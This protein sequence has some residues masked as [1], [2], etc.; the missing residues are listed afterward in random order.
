MIVKVKKITFVGLQ[1]EKERFIARLQEIGVTH[2]SLPMDAVEPAEVSRELQKVTEI[3]KFLSRL[4]KKTASAAG[5]EDYTAIC[6]RRE[7]LGQRET[8]LL[9]EISVLKKEREILEPWG[10]FAPQDIAA[11]RSKGLEIRFYR[12]PRKVFDTLSLD[13]VFCL[14][15][16]QSEGEV[17]FTAMASSPFDLGVPEEKIP[18]KS[19]KQ[20]DTDIQSKQEELGRITGEY[21][22]LSEKVQALIEAEAR[23]KDDYEYRRV[24]L[25]AGPV[26]D[27][28][29][30][31]LTCWSPVPEEDLLKR[32]GE[33]FTLGH[34]SED[35]AEGEKVPVLL[36]NR[37]AFESCEDLVKVYSQPN[38]GDFDPSGLVLYIF[39]IF[40]GMIIGD[41]GYGLVSLALTILLHWKV[42]SDSPLWFRFRRLCYLL[43]F[44][45]L[46][47]GIISASYFGIALRPENPLNKLLLLDLNT[48]EGQNQVMLISVIMGMIHISIALAIKFYRTKD[49]PTLGWIIVIW[50]GYFLLSSKMGKGEENPVAMYIAIVGMALVV[51]FT[52]NSKNPILRILIGL[53]GAL[54]VVQLLA[55][56]LSYMRLFALGLATMYMCQT[57][58]M[59]AEM[60]YNGLPYVGFIPAVLILVFG[61]AINLL[62]GVMGGVVHGLR[63]NFLEW[64]RWCFEGD[65]LPFR[66][67]K[68]IVKHA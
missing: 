14:I 28:R 48:K 26:L 38:Y 61:H 43:S 37:P 30:F 57:F 3:R 32:I 24:L 12:V 22:T 47:F 58:N 39:A 52:S 46:L 41:A 59:L 6:A 63:L 34:F 20:I 8:R 65:G 68:K 66:P 35:P 67:F 33:G 16:Q 21:K 60:P 56:C 17:A 45:V 18:A 54:G 4:G 13:S 1:E 7:E 10:E 27:N 31:V 49:L 36:S 44:S 15:T 42:K 55:D 50:S 29:L 5:G 25:N 23:L 62:L 64:Y 51:L 9:S 40:Y 11:L 19:L 2:V 53:N